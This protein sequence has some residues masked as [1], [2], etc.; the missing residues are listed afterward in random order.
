[1]KTKSELLNLAHELGNPAN[2]LAIVSEGNI[3]TVVDVETFIVKASGTHLRTLTEDQFVQVR[4][5]RILPMLEQE[6]DQTEIHE[7]LLASRIDP[8]ALKPSVE[9][10]FHAWLLR[11]RGV[12]FVG[13]VH[14]E[15][16]NKILCSKRSKDFAEKR[17]FP[18][19]IV[20]CGRKSLLIEYT[21]PG[22]KLAV[23]IKHKWNQFLEENGFSPVLILLQ[24]HGVIAV[25]PTAKAVLATSLMAAKAARIFVGA[26]AMGDPLFMSPEEVDR[27]QT[28]VDE[29]YRQQLLRN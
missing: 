10:I 22:L 28:R 24:N 5:E 26:C 6:F 21:D 25:G 29:H 23:A 13:H 14:P 15:E 19:E 12:K 4:F 11:Q 2:Q 16:V 18:D 27:I 17:L 7:T 9:T 8:R 20:C 1:M 3:S